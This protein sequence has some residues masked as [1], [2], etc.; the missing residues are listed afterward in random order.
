MASFALVHLTIASIFPNS[1]ILV[2]S[3]TPEATGIFMRLQLLAAGAD[4]HLKRRFHT[5]IL[6]E[7]SCAD[8]TDCA[9]RSRR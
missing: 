3:G 8:P 7:H 6:L 4:V 9:R 2:D 5:P 1:T